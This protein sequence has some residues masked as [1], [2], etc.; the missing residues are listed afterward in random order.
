M[1]KIRVKQYLDGN[2]YCIKIMNGDK[3]K[4]LRCLIYYIDVYKMK[5]LRDFS[6]TIKKNPSMCVLYLKNKSVFIRKVSKAIMKEM[7]LNENI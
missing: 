3:S 1:K 5:R 7:E 4:I 2:R 6:E